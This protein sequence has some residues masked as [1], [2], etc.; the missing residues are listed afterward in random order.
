M[1][2]MAV[3]VVSDKYNYFICRLR[4]ELEAKTAE[5]RLLRG[6]LQ[7][8]KKSLLLTLSKKFSICVLIAGGD[9]G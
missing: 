2:E 9:S 1:R 7:V 8:R 4:E 6:S 3:G 5:C